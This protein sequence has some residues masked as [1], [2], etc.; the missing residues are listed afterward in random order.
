MVELENH[1][2]V[3]FLLALSFDAPEES[4]VN[5]QDLTQCLPI[6]LLGFNGNRQE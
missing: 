6:Q 1:S 4:G 5:A 3:V 2:A